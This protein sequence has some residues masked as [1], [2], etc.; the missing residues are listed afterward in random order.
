MP[1]FASAAPASKEYSVTPL[2]W[3][4]IGLLC[5]ALVVTFRHTFGFIYSFW[6]IPEYSH[7]FL[8]PL[9]SALMLWQRRRELQQTPF[10]G[11]WA[12]I[13]LALVGFLMYFVGTVAAITTVDAYA[14]VVVIAGI[15]LAV[16]GWPAFR[17][18]LPAIA[19]LLLMNPIPQF[20]FNNLSSALQLLSSRIGVAVIRL[21]GI[22]V[23]LEGNVI[24]LGNYKLQVVEAC[25]GLRYLFPLLTLGVIVATMVRF[26]L[27]MR[28]VIV[29]ST[30]PI[31]ILMNSF[32]IG[33]IGVLVDRH[34]ISQAEGF[35]HDFE[36]WVI[37]MASF[38]LL[39]IEIWLLVRLRGDR[40]GLR[41]IIAIEW[42]EPRPK[43]TPLLGRALPASAVAAMALALVAAVGA[44]TLPDR[45]EKV[46]ERSEFSR[47]PLQVG[48]WQGRRDRIEA[49]YLDALKL[50]DYILAD[51][52]DGKARPV[53]FYVAWY[54][55]QRTGRAAHSPA[56][57]LPGGGWRM[58]RFEQLPVAGV[59]SGGQPL[60]VNRV[61]ISQ[62]D[63][64]Q[65]VYYWFKQRD[66]TV[67]NEYLVKWYM[68]WDSL[69][70]SRSDGALVRLIT[71][72]S[73]GETESAGDARLV[74]FAR[75]SVPLLGRFIPD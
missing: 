11:S 54:A 25:S 58:S 3:A 9:I 13:A 42:P 47:F 10:T 4:V 72:L 46:P 8:V 39:L 51:Y 65:L 16:A 24:D 55:S 38:V 14:L 45:E 33:V 6:Q 69:F 49:E 32:R 28:L 73:K 15:F 12:G 64:R 27:W 22:S 37:F 7:G 31:T 35:L 59:T 29:A 48:G 75:Q 40:R 43:G 30:V 57:C 44:T 34:G 61:V 41:E 19:L 2:L 23:F 52:G 36:G 60:R 17:I 26:P 5:V 74:D 70:R 50:D 18:A 62:G 71:P 20:L 67:T 21:F 56:S 68:L 1:D 66:R 53:N 63:E